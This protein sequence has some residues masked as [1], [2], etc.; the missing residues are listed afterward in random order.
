MTKNEI[1]RGIGKKR[2]TFKERGQFNANIHT[3]IFLKLNRVTI[4]LIDNDYK[5][6]QDWITKD[7]TT[8]KR[9]NEQTNK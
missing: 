3:C 8:I 6:C 7:N 1:M 9:R 5:S 4:K 2:G